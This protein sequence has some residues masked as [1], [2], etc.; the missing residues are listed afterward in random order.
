MEVWSLE[1]YGA[2]YYCRNSLTVKSDDVA[3]RVKCTRENCQGD[4]FLEAGL[5]GILQCSC[6]GTDEPWPGCRSAPGKRA[7]KKPKRVS[8]VREPDG[9]AKRKIT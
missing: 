1:A 6:Q 7:G 4:N 8:L 5:P 2:A 9:A 3:G